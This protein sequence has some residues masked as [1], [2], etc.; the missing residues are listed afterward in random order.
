[1]ARFQKLN[2]GPGFSASL[3][4]G[5]RLDMERNSQRLVALL[6]GALACALLVIAFLLGRMSGTP[7]APAQAAGSEPASMPMRPDIGEGPAE[8]APSPPAAA[9]AAKDG[10]LL[11]SASPFTFSGVER[12][13]S[14]ASLPAT[15]R[16]G[17]PASP[18]QQQV[19]AYFDQIER[20]G[21]LGGGDPQAF[22]ATLLQSVSSGDFSGFDS[23]AAQARTQRDHLRS[24]SPPPACREHHRLAQALATDSVVMLDRLRA[25]I[26]KGDTTALMEMA[27]EGRTLE[28]QANQL[29]AM[30][31]AIKQRA[32][33]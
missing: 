8:A 6:G 27:A 2:S 5:R 21:D 1:M 11:P 29:K 33:I 13:P 18:D 23:L 16:P 9:G 4:P 15:S 22:A 17:L 3:E 28:A 30:G 25:A 20:L 26:S 19:V 24:L 12:S 14:P 32:G 7:V 31:E 10:T